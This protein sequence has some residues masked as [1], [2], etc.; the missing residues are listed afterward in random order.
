MNRCRPLAPVEK[1]VDG[2]AQIAGSER[3]P[4]TVEDDRARSSCDRADLVRICGGLS[5]SGIISDCFAEGPG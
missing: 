1:S 2:R 5:G 4:H 3:H